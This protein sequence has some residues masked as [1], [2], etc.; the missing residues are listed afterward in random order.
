MCRAEGPRLQ[1]RGQGWQKRGQGWVC[2]PRRQ[3]PAA[4]GCVCLREIVCEGHARRG[5]PVL[6]GHMLSAAAAMGAQLQ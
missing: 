2:R 1:K 3:G 4:C 6:A 5:W